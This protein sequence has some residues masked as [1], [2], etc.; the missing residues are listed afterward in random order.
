MA[1][2]ISFT[3]GQVSIYKLWKT[4]KKIIEV[5]GGKIW[6]ENNTDDKGATFYFSLPINN[7]SAETP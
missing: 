4:A 2:F 1:K 3:I 6:A 5:H 7:R